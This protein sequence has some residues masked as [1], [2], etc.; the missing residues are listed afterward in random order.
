LQEGVELTGSYDRGPWSVY[1]NV[2]LSRAMGKD[3]ISSQ[4]NFSPDE[5]AFIANNWIHLDHDQKWTGSAG[6]AYTANMDSEYPTRMSIDATVQSG[7]RA[8][9]PTVPNGVALP[10]Y[11]VVN[12]SVV[13]KLASR[14]ELRL[15]I[16]NV[17]DNTYEIRNGTGVGVGAPQ[18]GIRR[19]ILA[20]VTQRF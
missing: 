11:G 4:N 1:G 13:Q 5:L 6:I 3:I 20:G 14:T 17:G 18:F 12:M 2:A 16:L 19:T 9:T 15:D 10:T 7:L 8:S